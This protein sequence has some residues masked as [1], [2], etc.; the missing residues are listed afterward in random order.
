MRRLVSV[1]V[2]LNLLFVTGILFAR[3]IGQ[4]QPLSNSIARLHLTDCVLPCWAGIVLGETKVDTGIEQLRKAFSLHDYNHSYTIERSLSDSSSYHEIR[5]QR[6]DD[7]VHF[8]DVLVIGLIVEHDIVEWIRLGTGY[9]PP[10]LGE[11]VHLYGAP[12]CSAVM[13]VGVDTL[14]YPSKGILL[15]TRE[16]PPNNRKLFT[17]I[18][19]IILDSP[20]IYDNRCTAY[21]VPWKGFTA[22]AK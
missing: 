1:L 18:T 17:P 6:T 20:D 14:M 4:T 15:N 3:L 9:E 7:N 12:Y 10:E 8:Y 16:F 19:E 21:T 2:I 22:K 5:L 13:T 11:L